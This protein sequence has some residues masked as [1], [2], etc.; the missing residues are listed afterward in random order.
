MSFIVFQIPVK[1]NISTG[2][3]KIIS[4]IKRI[5]HYENKYLSVRYT[6]P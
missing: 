2:V 6:A 4:I 1:I 3:V 5:N